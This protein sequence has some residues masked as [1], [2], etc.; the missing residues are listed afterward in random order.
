MQPGVK[1]FYTNGNGYLRGMRIDS[2]TTRGTDTVFHPYH[3]PR[4]VVLSFLSYADAL[5]STGASWLGKNVIKHVDGTFVFDNVWHDSVVINT[6]AH[7]GDTWTFF[8]DT[9]AISYKATLTAADTMTILGIVDSVKKITIEADISGV[10]NTADPVN[11]FEI[12]LSKN[13]GFV[14]VFD[15][16]TFPYHIPNNISSGMWGYDYY[17][18]L[19]TNVLPCECDEPAPHNYVDTTN[20]IFHIVPFHNPTLMELNNFSVGEVFEFHDNNSQYDGNYVVDIITLDTILS[21]TYTATSVNY[22][23]AEA[24]QNTT[25]T[26]SGGMTPYVTTSYSYGIVSS[27]YDT[28]LLM[29]TTLMPEEWNAAYFYHFFPKETYASGSVCPDT[30]CIVDVNNIAYPSGFVEFE[31]EMPIVG[32]SEIGNTTYTYS[33]GFG[34]SGISYNNYSYSSTAYPHTSET[35]GYMYIDNH[36]SIC[37][38]YESILPNAVS[39]INAVASHVTIFPNPANFQIFI[40]STN[41]PITQLSITNFLGQTVYTNEYNSQK[42]QVDISDLPAGIYFVKVNGVE[43]RKF[44]KQ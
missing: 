32:V 38:G 44:V 22:T 37:G 9:T 15:L 10:M 26:Y 19:V 27:S 21:K 25:T 30:V 11:N 24:Y 4:S 7:P 3:T 17:L 6:Q 42:V 28:T 1:P 8:S 40:R 13:H 39:Q 41:A 2:V 14:K 29:D 33:I 12:I 5:D 35:G 23:L 20:S 16:Y 18:D 43:V 34:K 36:D 31:A